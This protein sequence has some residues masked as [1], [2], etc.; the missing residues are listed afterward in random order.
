MNFDTTA[1]FHLSGGVADRQRDSGAGSPPTVV[2]AE[3]RA[4]RLKRVNRQQ[5][6]LRAV[7]VEKLIEADH[8]ARAEGT[9]IETDGA[10][11]FE[12]STR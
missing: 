11:P 1:T 12:F 9:G 7:D 4:P 3:E 5:M 2:G 6:V 8:T 10:G